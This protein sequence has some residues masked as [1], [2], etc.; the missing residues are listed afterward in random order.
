MSD[1]DL[2]LLVF[3]CQFSAIISYISL[4]NSIDSRFGYNKQEGGVG[5]R[6]NDEVVIKSLNTMIEGEAYVLG[7]ADGIGLYKAKLTDGRF[8]N[9]AGKAYL[10][11]GSLTSLSLRFNFGGTTGIE[12]AIVAPNENAAIYD[13]SGRRVMN[14]VKGGIY[15]KNGKKFIVK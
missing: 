2:L 11:A 14:V 3:F 15:I 8:L 1:S 5:G 12:E 10:P 13:L 7:N 9:N 6:N 4:F